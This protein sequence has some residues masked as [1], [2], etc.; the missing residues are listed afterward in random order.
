ML[1]TNTLAAVKLSCSPFDQVRH[2]FI[3]PSLMV[4]SYEFLDFKPTQKTTSGPPLCFIW[5]HERCS[6]TF[7]KNITKKSRRIVDVCSSFELTA[8][9]KTARNEER[10]CSDKRRILRTK[11]RI[12]PNKNLQY[13]ILEKK[14][15]NSMM[16][17]KINVL[18][19]TIFPTKIH[20]FRTKSHNFLTFYV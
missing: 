15:L 6:Q 17:K 20:D 8:T 18:K 13:V 14:S 4:Q 5:T 12:F 10:L 2:L 11:K 3:F 9:L 7:N 16:K 19:W 1:D